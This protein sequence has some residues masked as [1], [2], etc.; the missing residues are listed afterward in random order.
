M[1]TESRSWRTI[2][3]TVTGIGLV[4]L[5]AC[6]SQPTRF[7]TLGTNSEATIANRTTSPA[8]LIDMRT[9][10]VP[11]AVAK[12]QL[13]VQVNAAQVKILEDDRWASP[14][15]D[16]IRNALLADV[17]RQAG[18]PGGHAMGE[19][20]DVPV[21][22][23]SVDVQRFESWPGSHALIDAVWSVRA[24]NGPE[25]LTCH[26]I[27]SRPVSAGYYAIVDGHRRAIEGIAA[28]IAEGL[29]GF[30]GTSTVRPTRLAGTT[31]RKRK[32]TLS[33]PALVSGSERGIDAPVLDEAQ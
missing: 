17:T 11:A 32:A 29:R 5:T 31:G 13:V 15:A 21:Y 20:G 25:T 26:S 22:Q 12:S 16:E 18:A 24:L 2:V 1:V 7:Y 23:V 19:A 30:T 4:V 27:V 8:F 3:R 6:A 14:L 33:C 28:Q 10:R 9:V